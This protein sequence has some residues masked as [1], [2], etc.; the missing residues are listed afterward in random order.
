MSGP[1]FFAW[2]DADE[3]AFGPEHIRT[4]EL[5]LSV[6][7]SHSEGD[8]PSLD[9]VIINPRIGLLAPGRKLWA[10]LS[11]DRT[12]V[13]H[14]GESE[15]GSEGG[16]FAN[17]VPLFF[18]R[19]VGV[20]EDLDHEQ[21][22]LALIARPLDYEAQ[23]AAVAESKKVAPYWDPIWFSPD[24]IDDPDNI[25]ESRPELWHI[26]RTT[27]EVTTSNILV[28]ED[29][30]LAVGEDEAFYDS[31]RVSYGQA[32]VRSVTMTATV[33]WT[34]NAAGNIGNI[35]GSVQTF[36]GKGLESSWPKS[37]TDIGGGW[38]VETGSATRVG[39][40]RKPQLGYYAYQTFPP[41]GSGKGDTFSSKHAGDAYI[42]IAPP[43]QLLFFGR[44]MDLDPGPSPNKLNSVLQVPRWT[45][46]CNLTPAYSTSRQRSEVLTFTLNADVQ[47]IVTDPEGNG[48]IN[49]TMQS[50]EIASPCDLGGALPIG[51]VRQAVYFALGR[52]QQSIEYLICL[53]RAQLLARART[54]DIEFEVPGELAV[55]LGLSCRKSLVLTDRRLPGGEAGGKIKGYQISMNG[56][57]GVFVGHITLA[58]SIGKGG[59][60]TEAHG[61]PSYV[62][63]GYV[64]DGYQRREGQFVMPFPGEVNYASQEGLPPND[65]GVDF[66]R[67]TAGRCV[68]LFAH[69]QGLGAQVA[70]L[71]TLTVTTAG[72]LAQ[73]EPGVFP[74][75]AD[76]P[77]AV[78]KLL[79]AVADR[80]ALSMVPVTGGPFE[81]DYVVPV[82]DLKIPRTINLE[83][84]SV[85]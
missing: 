83:A 24:K 26:D 85:P 62:E 69:S 40:N 56:D 79:D 35:A 22:K 68:G 6:D 58:C 27:L 13:P 33:S 44:P 28:G 80:Y 59:T 8:F 37:G 64:E 18:G 51:D 46:S 72:G 15:D 48:V 16:H 34:Q 25:L 67:M 31:L 12:G 53:A 7:I 84:E 23:R 73:I 9:I 43:A 20:P 63:D 41:S 65:D 81:T 11:Y 36:T 42:F 19:L 77:E 45:L 29:G 21:V 75:R 30:T 50:S 5:I 54:V 55:E 78:F 10:W 71:D 39:D 38:K 32:P 17:V 3:T 49:L 70:A 82:S 47:S 76:S 14:P 2:A 60:V 66:F 4:D 57:S 1:W 61:S 52:G 74:K